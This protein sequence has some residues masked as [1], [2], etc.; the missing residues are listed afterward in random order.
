MVVVVFDDKSDVDVALLMSMAV[1]LSANVGAGFHEC[2]T[3]PI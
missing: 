3:Y 2:W 1:A